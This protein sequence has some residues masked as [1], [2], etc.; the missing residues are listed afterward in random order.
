MSGDVP[1]AAHAIDWPGIH[2]RLAQAA[3][4]LERRAAPPPAEKQRILRERARRLAAEPPP[5]GAETVEVLEFVL[6][7]EHYAVE[8]AGVREVCPL[9][10]LAP[11]P[12]APP[13]VLGIINVR[14]RIVSVVD[15]KKFFDLPARGLTDLN[16]VIIVG[17]GAM[18][19]GL[20]ADAVPGIRRIAL[21]GAGD[22]AAPLPAGLRGEYVKA[23]VAGPLA[24]LDLGTFLADPG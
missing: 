2:R 5:A 22:A 19:L 18:E 7:Y 10:H 14:G 17:D 11:V 12:G 23:V 16:K 9:R 15:L 6:A 1:G 8:L 21:P 24:V 13:F 3:V 4:A 20:M